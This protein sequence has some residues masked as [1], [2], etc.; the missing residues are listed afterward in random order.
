M[1][2]SELRK[3]ES[4]LNVTRKKQEYFPV[5]FISKDDINHAF[6]NDPKVKKIVTGMDDTDMKNLASKMADDYCEQLFWESLKAIFEL[7]FM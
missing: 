2:L 5:T 3:T 1:V 7:K 6:N 4:N